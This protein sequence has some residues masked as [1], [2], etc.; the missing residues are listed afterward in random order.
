MESQITASRVDS[1]AFELH[2]KAA[3]EAIAESVKT[4][5]DSR[6]IRAEAVRIL[7]QSRAIAIKF[8]PS[9]EHYEPKMPSP[10]KMRSLLIQV[11]HERQRFFRL[12]TDLTEVIERCAHTVTH[13]ARI[14]T[15]I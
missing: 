7:E 2:L 15:G 14:R 4:R 11:Q 5:A 8:C 1:L 10:R 9:E 12:A 13:S 3:R 6:A